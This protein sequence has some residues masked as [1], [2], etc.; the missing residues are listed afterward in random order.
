[1]AVA[2]TLLESCAAARKRLAS[3]I[4][5]RSPPAAV[6][7]LVASSTSAWKVEIDQL[8]P[9]G[10]KQTLP[11]LWHVRF[12]A[13]ATAIAGWGVDAVGPFVLRGV[14]SGTDAA[15]AQVEAH[16][17]Y[18]APMSGP[19]HAFFQAVS[20]GGDRDAIA[21]YTAASACGRLEIPFAGLDAL[22]FDPFGLRTLYG[23]SATLRV[24]KAEDAPVAPVPGAA[25]LTMAGEWKSTSGRRACAVRG[26][27]SGAFRA[28]FAG[29]LPEWRP[30]RGVAERVD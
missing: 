10:R 19:E 20:D 8:D 1:M 17:R 26:T 11:S 3:G 16:K 30:V 13:D 25:S 27:T 15:S 5:A 6:R 22:L 9:R 2:R 7:D 23:Y 21:M 4:V 24:C 18:V 12:L 14:I 29:V 28:G